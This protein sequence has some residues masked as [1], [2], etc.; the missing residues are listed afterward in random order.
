M[1][2]ASTLRLSP[3][4]LVAAALV[5]LAVLLVHDSPPAQAQQKPTVT[6]SV[7]SNT[8]EEDTEFSLTI[9]L[10]SALQS[11]VTIPLETTRYSFGRIRS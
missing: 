4:L 5:A 3:F 2:R 8:A 7:A 6:L 1:M 11:P 9:T 10:S